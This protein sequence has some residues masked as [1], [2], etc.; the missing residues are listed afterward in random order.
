MLNLPWSLVVQLATL[1]A[2]MAV[3]MTGGWLWQRARQ[4][5]GIV[6]V[7]WALGLAGAALL[8]AFTGAG[9]AWPRI[10]LGILGTTWALRLGLH[11][12][13]RVSSEPEDG[14]Y[15]QLRA[16]W[17]GHQ[18][19]FLLFFLFQAGLVVLFALPFAGVAANPV[20]GFT[21][22][23][24]LGVL[25][26]AGAVYGEAAAD[27][28]LAHFR[29]QPANRGLTCRR[30]LWRYSRHPNYFFEWL[31]WFAYVALG[32]GSPLAW[33]TWIGPL[34]MYMFLRWVSGIPFT[35]A[36]ALR[37]RGEDYR[38]YQRTTPMLFPWFPKSSASRSAT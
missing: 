7:L 13:Q 18:G 5:T 33:L 21:P 27:R 36:Q 14:R 16:R 34:V 26:W 8:M 6:D 38:D 17:Q 10:A 2:G 20:Q 12:W 30:G 29:A 4:N 32:V 11:L 1:A 28:Q 23:L 15:Q 37:T 9:A 31:H 22:N 35:E 25:I 24:A 19:K 3:V